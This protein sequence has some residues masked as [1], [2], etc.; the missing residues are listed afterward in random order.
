MTSIP[1]TYPY[2]IE[3]RTT[4][5]LLGLI[6]Q[7]ADKYDSYEQF[8]SKHSEFEIIICRCYMELEDAMK[9][10]RRDEKRKAFWKKLTDIVNFVMIF[11]RK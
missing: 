7:L 4:E 6:N 8:Q 5:T 3:C 11:D 1:Q 2:L 9:K 10:Y